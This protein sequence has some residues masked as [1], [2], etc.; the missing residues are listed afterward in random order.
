MM[1]FAGDCMAGPTE[2]CCG[3]L[4]SFKVEPCVHAMMEGMPQAY[5]PMV[6]DILTQCSITLPA[7]CPAPRPVVT[8]SREVPC[9]AANEARSCPVAKCM[10]PDSF[11]AGCEIVERYASNRGTCC[12]VLCNYELNGKRCEPK[13]VPQREDGVPLL[14]STSFLLFELCITLIVSILTFTLPPS[15]MVMCPMDMKTCSDG[16][17]L[18]R[19]TACNFPECPTDTDGS[20]FIEDATITLTQMADGV[21]LPATSS[22]YL[23]SSTNTAPPLDVVKAGADAV[24]AMAGAAADLN[25]TLNGEDNST[26]TGEAMQEVDSGAITAATMPLVTLCAIIASLLL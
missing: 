10:G 14:P 13:P 15:E 21:F 12:P 24:E 11:P 20:T 9:N 23:E 25:Q 18:S 5:A 1:A 3:G 22:P 4:A 19:D 16:T 8:E 7:K 2:A 26:S 17:M 6:Q